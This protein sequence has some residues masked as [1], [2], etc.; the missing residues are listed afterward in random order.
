MGSI[1]HAARPAPRR[2]GAG[3]AKRSGKKALYSGFRPSREPADI[4]SPQ[5]AVG[6]R[7][8]LKDHELRPSKPRTPRIDFAFSLAFL[9]GISGFGLR[10]RLLIRVR[11]VVR[12]YPGPWMEN[13]A[14]LEVTAS[15]WVLLCAPENVDQNRT[16][17]S[18]LRP[19]RC[20]CAGRTAPF[21]RG[22]RPD[23]AVAHVIV[24]PSSLPG[25]PRSGVWSPQKRRSFRRT[26]ASCLPLRGPAP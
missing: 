19:T 11:L 21:L 26:V 2:A 18:A 16:R 22:V 7:F 6:Y 25:R 14:P 15:G 1:R 3:L 8:P 17:R 10:C 4:D 5:G 23:T 24:A 12:V 13:A 20:F 9:C